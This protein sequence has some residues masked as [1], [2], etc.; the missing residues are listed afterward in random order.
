LTRRSTSWWFLDWRKLLVYSHRWLGIAGCLL[1]AAWFLSGIV[2]MYARMPELANEERLGRASTLDLSAA[3]LSPNEAAGQAAVDG[4]RFT[5]TMLRGRPAYRF[6]SNRAATIVFADNGERFTGMGAGEALELARRY[7]PHHHGSFTYD[8]YLT[9]P[10][11]WTLQ[12]RQAMPMHRFVLDDDEATH[13]YVSERTGTVVLRTTRRERFWGYLGPVIHWVYF[14]PLRQR[15]ALWSEAIIWSSLVGCVMCVIGLI[16]GAWRFSPFSRYRLKRARSMTPYAGMMMWHHYAGLLFGVVTL[17]WTYSG[18]LSMGPFNWFQDRSPSG[19]QAGASR[20][21]SLA[22]EQ[23]TLDSMRRAVT[24]LKPSFEP[25]ELE[26]VAFKG[27]LFWTALRAPSV[28]DAE[29]WMHAGLVPRAPLPRLEQRYVSARRPEDGTFDRFPEAAMI[30]IAQ[31][32][33]PDIPVQDSTWLQAYDGYYYDPRGTLSL[34]VLRVRYNDANH[35][36]LYL[37]P[38]R[39]GIVE[40]SVG[41]TRLRR[42][43]YHGLHSL[44]FPFLYYRRPLW[45]IVVV[46]LSIGGT[47]LSV[48]T[49]LPVW[50]RLKR[51]GR[52]FT[53]AVIRWR[54]G[55]EP[56]AVN[57]ARRTRAVKQSAI[58]RSDGDR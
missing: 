50:R 53:N 58:K 47:V 37:D 39:G 41:I 17:T 7:A 20:G 22:R 52:E 13:L 42:W 21:G 56:F 33:M 16:W 9:A 12:A 57:A 43:L 18:L 40:R 27:D 3:V 28:E 49:L 1:F 30:E 48:T 51:R 45:D 26:V 19:A 11:Q 31:A 23:L 4:D 2:M 46:V 6:G 5:V 38:A 44:D 8:R 25:K 24:A 29:R 14:T 34:P 35:T 36:W 32:A 55:P 10:D 54:A 15:G